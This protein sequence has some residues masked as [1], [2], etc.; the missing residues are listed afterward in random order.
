MSVGEEDDGKMEVECERTAGSI[1]GTVEGD[2]VV[3]CAWEEKM[4]R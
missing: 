1:R 2:L 3:L 4:E